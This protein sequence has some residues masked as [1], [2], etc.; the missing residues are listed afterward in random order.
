MQTVIL[1]GLSYYGNKID[2]GA[3][4]QGAEDDMWR[5]VVKG[6]GFVAKSEGKE[7]RTRPRCRCEQSDC[8]DFKYDV[9]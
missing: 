8:I 6:R 9:E 2:R 7:S 3:R 4:E 5:L 1:F